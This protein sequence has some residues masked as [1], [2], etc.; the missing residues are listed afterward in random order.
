MIESLFAIGD[1][2]WEGEEVPVEL[3]LSELTSLCKYL[4]LNINFE[5]RSVMFKL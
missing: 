5:E 1:T 3:E 4:G 2:M